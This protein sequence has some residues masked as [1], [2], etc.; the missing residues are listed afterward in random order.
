MPEI[1]TIIPFP[2]LVDSEADCEADLEA[3]SRLASF[4][5]KKEGIF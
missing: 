2:I 4:T 1:Q 3:K 5:K